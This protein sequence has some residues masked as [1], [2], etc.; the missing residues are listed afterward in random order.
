MSL[1]ILA[2]EVFDPAL[3]GEYDLPARLELIIDQVPTEPTHVELN[4]GPF[5]I[6]HRNWL[7]SIFSDEPDW[8]DE[9][10]TECAA[11]FNS[12]MATE[13]REPVMPVLIA[14]EDADG[15]VW[16]D[17]YVKVSRINRILAKLERMQGVQ[18]YEAI[19]DPTYAIEKRNVWM[20]QHP[21]RICAVC[22][23][24]VAAESE[25]RDLVVLTDLPAGCK[26][27]QVREHR[28]VPMCPI[29]RKEWNEEHREYREDIG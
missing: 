24:E 25:D 11:I 16:Q 15:M 5:S 6:I 28:L 13:G 7:Q 29:H 9:D 2:A 18:G 20:L 4:Q 21:K 10:T 19:P 23:Q 8:D 1:N 3:S 14:S 22:S 12:A 27:Q 17:F 26:Y